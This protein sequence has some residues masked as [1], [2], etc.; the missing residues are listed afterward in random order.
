MITKS[1]GKYSEVTGK[2]TEWRHVDINFY[3]AS[4]A[5]YRINEYDSS[6]KLYYFILELIF[7]SNRLRLPFM[8]T[9]PSETFDRNGLDVNAFIRYHAEIDI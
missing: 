6:K 7:I 3:I 1:Q 9:L 4:Y 5:Y 8:V 2:I